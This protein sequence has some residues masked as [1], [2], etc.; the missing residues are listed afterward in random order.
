MKRLAILVFTALLLAGSRGTLVSGQSRPASSP[1]PQSY[2]TATTAILV[3][4]VVRDRKGRPVTDLTAGD[5]EVYEDR[6]AQKIDTFTRVTRGGGIGLDVKWKQPGSTVAIFPAWQRA[7]RVAGP[8]GRRPG[9]DRPG[10]RSPG[11][12]VAWAG[13]E[14]DARVRADGRRIRRTRWC[15]RHRSR[16]SRDAG[17]T[18]RTDRPSGVPSARSCRPARRPPSRRPSGGTK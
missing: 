3:D 5:F 7:A 13:A 18:P 15:V 16:N 12:G 10:V 6:V 9:D 2:S 1:D 8:G 17:A 4:V 11:G 14:G